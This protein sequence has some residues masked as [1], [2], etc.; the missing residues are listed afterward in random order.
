MITMCYDDKCPICRTEA[1]HMAAKK[2]NAI[3]IM[4]IADA[5]DELATFGIS[6]VDAM[7]YL[8]VKDSKGEIHKGMDAIRL[9]YKIAELPFASALSLPIVKQASEVI[10]PIFARNRNRIPNWVAK[11]VYGKVV[12][13]CENGMC[14]M[15]GS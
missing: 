8:C 7:A 6:E 13:G 10:Y 2:P 9:L 5:I 4:P 15:R 14:K 11:L 12:D 1:L 3:R